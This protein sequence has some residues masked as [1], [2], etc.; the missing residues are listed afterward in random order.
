MTVDELRR[1]LDEFPDHFSVLVETERDRER[2]FGV[3][4]WPSCAVLLLGEGA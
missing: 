3:V 1:A 2:V 4:P